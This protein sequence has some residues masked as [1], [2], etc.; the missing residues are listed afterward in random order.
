MTDQVG[1]I[2]QGRW[3]SSRQ[4]LDFQNTITAPDP[5]DKLQACKLRVARMD[6][7]RGA[8]AHR[9]QIIYGFWSMIVGTAPPFLTQ[10]AEPDAGLT[11]ILTAHACFQGVQ[12]AVGDDDDGS[13]MIAYVMKPQ[14]QYRFKFLAPIVF[15]EKIPVPRDLV[16][17]AFAHLDKPEATSDTIG[18]LTHWQ[19]IEADERNL[20]LPMDYDTRYTKQLW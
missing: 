8:E 10:E 11:S 5:I 3:V 4:W 6:L 2:V 13:R 7:I 16:F 19:L 17:V 1:R 20:M 15:S 14:F 12:R 18:I 9:R